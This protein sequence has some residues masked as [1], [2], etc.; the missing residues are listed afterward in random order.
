M[1]AVFLIGLW[2]LAPR[3]I[4]GQAPRATCPEIDTTAAWAQVSR[5]WFDERG[6]RWTNDS[7]R[8][9]LIALRDRDQLA[10]AGFG[11]QIMDSTYVRRLIRLDSI[12]AADL[13]LILDRY[14]VPTRS[15]V[16]AAGSAAA[17]LI[18]Q[19]NWPLQERVLALAR[20]LPSGELSPEALGMLTDRVLTHQGRPQLLGSQ[21][22]LGPD[23][24]FRL[25]P[26]ADTTHLDAR[27]AAAGMP[28][29]RQYVCLMEASGMRIDHGSLPAPFRP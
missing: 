25:D 15:L 21:F 18:V 7:L 8:R 27:R 19:H 17:M 22:D 12:L 28:P 14:G 9:V 24:Q 5:A 11:A 20:A 10:R 23:G 16:G 2:I 13:T 29:M 3:R 1:Y 4:H 6:H 26:I